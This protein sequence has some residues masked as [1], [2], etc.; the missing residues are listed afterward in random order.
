MALKHVRK[1]S[2]LLI[3][4]EMQIKAR[5]RFHFLPI[6]LAKIKKQVHI[7][8]GRLWENR[9]SQIGTTFLKGNVAIPNKTTRHV[10]LT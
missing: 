8:L 10:P 6:R 3:I 5:L 1:C 7:L 4:K 9:H 2:S